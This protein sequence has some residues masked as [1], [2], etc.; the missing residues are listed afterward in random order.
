MDDSG[1]GQMF[2]SAFKHANAKKAAEGSEQT[3]ELTTV[4]LEEAVANLKLDEST[5]EVLPTE[6]VSD[7]LK[8]LKLEDVDPYDVCTIES[9]QYE[10][11]MNGIDDLLS[12][13]D[14]EA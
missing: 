13:L 10:Q 4:G 14:L 3:S 8:E 6:I 5:K 7:A 12:R 11:L 9:I 1:L 2:V